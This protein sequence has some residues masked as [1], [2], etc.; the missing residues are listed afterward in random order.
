M[1]KSFIAIL[2]GLIGAG[3]VI[4]LVLVLGYWVMS[5]PDLAQRLENDNLRALMEQVPIS[6]FIVVLVAW[7]IG[8]FTGAAVA[9]RIADTRLI[10][11][12]MAV[13]AALT[14]M[15]LLS[16]LS[17]PYPAWFW[18]LNLVIVLPAAILGAWLLARD[19]SSLPAESLSEDEHY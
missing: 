17:I 11:H 1:W 6:A 14:L 5:N 13:G 9:A 3:L 8:G 12:G 2:A 19:A 7:S 16:L 18:F 10:L 15:A 4:T